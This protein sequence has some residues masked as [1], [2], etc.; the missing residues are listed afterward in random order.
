MWD[1]RAVS[2]KDGFGESTLVPGFCSGGRCERTPVPGFSFRGTSECTLVPVF[3]LGEHPPKGPKPTPLGKPPSQWAKRDTLMSRGENCRETIFVSQLSRSYPHRG[4]NFERGQ[5]ALL[6]W[7]RDRYFGSILG[8]NLGEG[9]CESKI[10]VGS[11]FLPRD[12][13]VSRRALWAFGN[14]RFLPS[15]SSGGENSASSAC[16]SMQA[17]QVLNV[18]A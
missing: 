17:Q 3:V 2:S 10:A 14:P 4:G 8:D 16:Q 9:N 7:A 12:I 1:K 5:N 15:P 18:G 13:K 6:L 11:Q